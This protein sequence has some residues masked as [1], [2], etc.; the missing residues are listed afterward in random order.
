MPH[1]LGVRWCSLFSS[2]HSYYGSKSCL[3]YFKMVYLV[4]CRGCAPSIALPGNRL[5]TTAHAGHARYSSR[6]RH[7]RHLEHYISSFECIASPF[8]LVVG[9]TIALQPYMK[10]NP[11]AVTLLYT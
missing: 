4:T 10:G 3:L 5:G 6:S 9:S 11:R 8:Q 1:L 7:S 2:R